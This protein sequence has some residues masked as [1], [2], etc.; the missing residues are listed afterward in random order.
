MNLGFGDVRT[1]VKNLYCVGTDTEKRSAGV[2]RSAYS[3]LKC[4]DLMRSD[5]DPA[6]EFCIG[7]LPL[8]AYLRQV[9]GLTI[10]LQCF[11]IASHRPLPWPQL[12][13]SNWMVVCSDAEEVEQIF[14]DLI[15]Y[16]L[17][18]EIV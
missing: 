3:V 6:S 8:V 15:H 2:N 7:M 4:L 10:S 18:W 13:C 9:A 11:A 14:F 12:S 17:P 16:R 5:G 1:P